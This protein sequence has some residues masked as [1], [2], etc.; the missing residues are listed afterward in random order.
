MTTFVKGMVTVNNGMAS[1]RKRAYEL[2]AKVDE[3]SIT[4][5]KSR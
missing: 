3:L 1:E 2:D 5:E 4:D